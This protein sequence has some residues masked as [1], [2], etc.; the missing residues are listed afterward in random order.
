MHSETK[1]S[2]AELAG[3]EREVL[4]ALPP[5]RPPLACGEQRKVDKLATIRFASAYSVPHRLVGRSV[6][7]LATDREL[8]VTF[9]GVPAAHHALLGPGE[10][11]VCDEHYPAP[12]PSGM[13]SLRPRTATE[14]AFLGLGA[15]AE[16]YL[17]AG[18]AA[19]AARLS[20]RIDDAP[21]IAAIHGDGRARG[22]LWRATRFGRFGRG[23]LE[24]IADALGATP[25]E[26]R[27]DAAP[28]RLPGVPEI[29]TRPISVYAE[30]AGDGRAA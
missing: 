19:G 21:Q 22:A 30:G 6:E 13:R 3:R 14:R 16:G 1:R 10:V 12:P 25:P 7:A 15:Q 27:E 4:R 2:P 11:S 5:E 20:Q 26:R 18:A 8:I 9:G 17:R 28:L 24:A 29:P 23:D